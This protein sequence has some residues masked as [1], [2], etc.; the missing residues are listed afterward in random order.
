MKTLKAFSYRCYPLRK[1]TRFQH[2]AISY[3]FSS[4]DYEIKTEHEENM[5]MISHFHTL[6]KRF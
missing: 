6:L 5:F 3:R 4:K 1:P 2:R